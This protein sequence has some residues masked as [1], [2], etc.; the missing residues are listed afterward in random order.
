MSDRARKPPRLVGAPLVRAMHGALLARFGGLDGR[1]DDAKLESALARV[2]QRLAYGDPPPTIA[3]LAAECAFGIAR[4]HPFSDGN[5]RVALATA[6]M[7]LWLNG[8]ELRADEV[9]TVVVVQALA[10]GDIG[11]AELARWLDK[12]AVAVKRKR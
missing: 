10:A 1:C 2:A 4:N 8:F 12:N 3:E 9:D 11:V 5:K 6:D 7:I